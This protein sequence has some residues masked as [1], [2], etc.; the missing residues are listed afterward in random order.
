MCVLGVETGNCASTQFWNRIWGHRETWSYMDSPE[1][2]S[3]SQCEGSLALQAGEEEGE[4]TQPG[5]RQG[6]AWTVDMWGKRLEAAE[7]ASTVRPL[8]RS[9]AFTTFLSRT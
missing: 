9:L 3:L 1:T 4:E 8:G 6:Y 2:T 7:E 5:V